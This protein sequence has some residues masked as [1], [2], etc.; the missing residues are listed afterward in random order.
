L[1]QTAFSALPFFGFFDHFLPILLGSGSRT[2]YQFGMFRTCCKFGDLDRTLVVTR[3]TD[4]GWPPST[5]VALAPDS[6]VEGGSS[7]LFGGMILTWFEYDLEVILTWFEYL[8]QA[9][10]QSRVL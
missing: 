9:G 8:C 2:C 6:S 10:F 3:P 1:G 7:Y 4:H 5:L